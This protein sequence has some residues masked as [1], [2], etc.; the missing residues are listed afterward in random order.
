[1]GIN[2]EIFIRNGDYFSIGDSFQE[3]PQSI[4]K[5]TITKTV[6]W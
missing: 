4:Q 1:M 6:A 5:N 2:L 3:G